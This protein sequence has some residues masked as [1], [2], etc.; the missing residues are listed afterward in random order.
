MYV[1]YIWSAKSWCSAQ[2]PDM[3]NW[4]SHHFKLPSS[5]RND[6]F[7]SF[8]RSFRDA[9]SMIWDEFYFVNLRNRDD[10]SFEYDIVFPETRGFH[11]TV[12]FELMKS[13]GLPEIHCSLRLSSLIR[14]SLTVCFMIALGV[15]IFYILHMPQSFGLN[16]G[17]LYCFA[18]LIVYSSIV[19]VFQ[20]QMKE[21][22]KALRQ[23]WK[24][25][26]EKLR[27]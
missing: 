19:I 14:I 12:R 4:F 24:D 20:F 18:F 11:P 3:F 16:F 27:P 21:L 6:D 13:D 9:K 25:Q 7:F 23:T 10:T 26:C 17:L 22:E 5:Q 15:M 2:F 1:T 8:I